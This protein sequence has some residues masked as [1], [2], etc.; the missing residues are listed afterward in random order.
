MFHPSIRIISFLFLLSLLLPE[1]LR[2]A[3]KMI[4]L[5]V[6]DSVLSQALDKSLPIAID[7]SSSTLS[8][9]I[10]IIRIS[11]LQIQDKGVSCRIALK[12]DDMQLSTEI[13]GHTIKL[14]VGSVQLELQ[15]NAALRFDPAKQLLYVKP[16][17]SDLQASSTSAQGDINALLMGFLNNREFPVKM[18]QLEPL[19]AETSG[20]TITINM[21]IAGI[22][23]R[24]GILQFDIL[25]TIQST[26]HTSRKKT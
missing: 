24:Q 23:T 4:T 20:K 1:Q 8:G 13:S 22:S 14:K 12:G 2:A 9:A 18:Q 5:T 10:T 15:C 19:I 7:T 16:V 3:G 26:N 21:N 17:I 6:P 25:P 11:N